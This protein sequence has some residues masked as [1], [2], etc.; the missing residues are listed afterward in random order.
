[1]TTPSRIILTGFS[2]TGKSVVG[3]ILAERLGAD[4]VDTDS[5]IELEAGKSILDIFRDEGERAFRDLESRALRRACSLG[6]AVIS[7]GGG[8]VLSPD[9]R[10]RMA[11][12]GFIVCL[13]ARPETI[14]A[15]LA[16]RAEDASPD[17]P[18]LATG[19]SLSRI[20]DLKAVRQHLYALSDWSVHT[21]GL[22]PE[23]V[24]DEITHALDY[25]AT[26]ILAA[27]LRIDAIT[28]PAATAP[29]TTPVPADA[30]CVVHTALRDYPVIVAWGALAT[31][32]PRL[33][34]AG[35]ATFAYVISDEQV[36]HHLG[37]EIEGSLRAAGIEFDSFTVPPGEESKTL[38]SA[39]AIYDWLIG[40]QAERGHVV[41]AVGGGVAT[42]LG[43]YVAA[44]YA[45]GL[46][47]VHVPTSMLGMVDAA[48][49][50]KVAVNHPHAKN[51]IGFFHQ[52]RF[53]LAD[54]AVLRTLP[55]RE[56]RSGL[57]EAIKHGLI[58][59]ETYLRFLEDNA[60]AILRLDPEI[61]TQAISRSAQIKAEVVSADE[62]E[63]TGR[64]STLNY[65][66]TLAHAIEST[67]GYARFRHGEADGVGM[68]AAAAMS[69]RMGLLDPAVV[70]RQR[71]VLET[72]G[73]PTHADGLD[74]DI[75][76]A[77]VALD[78]KVQGKKVRWVLLE[79]IGRPV[80]RDD[81]P[82]EI[83]EAA[84]DEVLH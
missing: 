13:E 25:R 71:R 43:G 61:T 60:A 9:N 64:R 45:R 42:D 32:G 38:A 1:M 17:R 41:A 20:R 73:L 50:G 3:P 63:T 62:F 16:G 47:L 6:H 82:A 84:L 79:A 34:E 78:K 10:N 36:W 56:I 66:H 80:L 51:M 19:D 26:A 18:L 77:A 46:P 53:V 68:M 65:G 22:T 35:L 55:P 48:I 70:D 58:A 54:P 2:G 23:E 28:A 27:P 69:V 81:V 57:A 74:R 31:L 12:S 40:H 39:S 75:L 11:E 24:A 37:D 49:G 67:T 59:N 76:L 14:A 29:S 5:L 83:V 21:D 15:R 33:R 30:A 4:L 72:Y 7:T 8:A 44:T 52:P